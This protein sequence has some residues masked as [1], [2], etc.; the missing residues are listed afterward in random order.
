MG[1][2]TNSQTVSSY[3]PNMRF[4][5]SFL[6]LDH[7]ARA[8][9]DEV[10]MD[11]RTG[12]IVYKRN[13]DGKLIYYAQENMHLNNYM[14]QLKTLMTENRKTYI[15]PSITNCEDCE[16][17]YFISYNIETIDF[18]FADPRKPTFM[19]GGILEN[20]SPVE[21]SF[22]QE[23]NGF[24]IQ[25][26]GR[27]RDRALLSFMTALYDTY[28]KNYD[29]TDPVALERKAMFDLPN[30]DTSNAVVNYTVRYYDGTGKVVAESTA[31]GYVRAN[32][33]SYV[34]F[35]YEGIY[36]R[37]MVAYATIKI[38]SIST[39]KVASLRDINLTDGQD[40]LFQ[41][42]F[43]NVEFAF[44]SCNIS[45]FVCS[46]D[47]HFTMPTPSNT[48]SLLV[49][50]WEEFE[51]ELVRAKTGGG[52]SGIVIDVTEP[53]PIDWED[54]TIWAEIIRY[55]NSD[56]TETETDHKTNV[57]DLEHAFESIEYCDGILTPDINAVEDYYVGNDAIS[58]DIG[59]DS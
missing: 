40:I 34:P 23:T 17:V 8:V 25:L 41:A 49:M 35:V 54:I 12:Q 24:F 9:D 59:G 57:D 48:I 13:T 2:N 45:I 26:N 56:G 37:S 44:I 42:L 33:I 27:P 50:S 5:T 39:P 47:P 29:G 3:A 55:V 10:L 53:D 18:A 1:E 7:H 4:G 21:H 58:V 20:D 46:E 14:R 6:S 15:R 11:K 52:S 51:E 30:Y 36:P 19:T 38:N 32:E 43:D 16:H 31:D 28:Y 22:V